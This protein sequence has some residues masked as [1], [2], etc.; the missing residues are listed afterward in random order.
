MATS[1]PGALDIGR[2]LVGCA[3]VLDV[4]RDAFL[5]M[6]REEAGDSYDEAGTRLGLLGGLVWQGWNKALDIVDHPDE[7]DSGT[8]EG[9]VAVVA[10][11]RPR[12]SRDRH[13]TCSLGTRHRPPERGR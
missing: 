1:A 10:G 13:V 8:G 4:D 2:F 5:A 11:P 3:H 12:G 6:Y 9:G 7:D